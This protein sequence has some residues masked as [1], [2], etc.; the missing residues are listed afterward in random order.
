MHENL[1]G[2]YLP[3]IR[4]YRQWVARSTG[5]SC[6][7][8]QVQEVLEVIGSEVQRN[9]ILMCRAYVDMAN[10]MTRI[11]TL[12]SALYKYTDTS[13]EY[14]QK[15]M[16]STRF[17]RTISDLN[18]HKRLLR[19][20]GNSQN[21]TQQRMGDILQLTIVEACNLAHLDRWSQV[22]ASC[23]AILTDR[24]GEQVSSAKLCTD[25]VFTSQ[26]PKWQAQFVV[27]LRSASLLLIQ[28][29][30]NNEVIKSHISA[31]VVKKGALHDSNQ[32]TQL[33]SHCS[34]LGVCHVDLDSLE[35]WK[36]TDE[37]YPIVNKT[38]GQSGMS[39]LRLQCCRIPHSVAAARMQ[40]EVKA[41]GGRTRTVKIPLR[42]PEGGN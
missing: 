42:L 18:A 35:D 31:V 38:S 14:T 13:K 5:L 24:D 36:E 23:V 40:A 37:W 11:S 39:K 29:I 12:A 32:K 41:E 3:S 19:T 17:K 21:P 6:L 8:Y 25:V 16:L 7:I 30:N 15:N 1:C 20:Q 10:K 33:K 28:V 34:N 26:E 4:A 22:D 9:K 27:P 2:Q